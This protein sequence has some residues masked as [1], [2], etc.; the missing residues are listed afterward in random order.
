MI[1]CLCIRA[2]GQYYPT[3]RN[4]SEKQLPAVKEFFTPEGL[5]GRRI[6]FKKLDID[7]LVI[8]GGDG[9]F[10]GADIFSRMNLIFLVSVFPVLSIKILPVPISPLALILL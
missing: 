5:T 8:I 2:G 6:T 4:H 10:R 9:S 3:R 1:L 7:G